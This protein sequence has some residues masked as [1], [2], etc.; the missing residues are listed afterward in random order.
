MNLV[1]PS[2]CETDFCDHRMTVFYPL[3]PRDHLI[4]FV[5]LFIFNFSFGMVMPHESLSIN[6]V[7]I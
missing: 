2:P 5:N 6:I 1:V 4:H 7:T 3:M